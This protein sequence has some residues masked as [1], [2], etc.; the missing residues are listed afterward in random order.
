MI[1]ALFSERKEFLTAPAGCWQVGYV[2]VMTEGSPKLSSFT[3]WDGFLKLHCAYLYTFNQ[4]C[5]FWNGSGSADPYLW[6]MDPD[7]NPD[8]IIFVSEIL[9]YISFAPTF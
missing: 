8:Y 2:D 9:Q 5:G 6:L 3:R 7:A 4:C 1:G